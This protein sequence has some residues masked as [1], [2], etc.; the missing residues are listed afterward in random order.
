MVHL[1]ILRDNREQ[2]P[3]NFDKQD[4]TVEDV[5]LDTGD[6]TLAEFCDYDEVND[7]YLPWYAIERKSGDDFID[8]ITGSRERFK[9]EIKRASDWESPLRVFIE[10]PKTVFKRQQDFMEYRDVSWASIKGTV[11][12]WEQYY[13]VEFS[14][15]GGREACQ[16]KAFD[17]L[18]T[19]LRATLL[20]DD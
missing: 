14:F 1:N 18:S 20:S 13:N 12:T 5:T 2:L 19:N 17:T 3:W 8:S 6:Y 4:V 10:S 7:T 9:N 11:D 15:I 16:Q